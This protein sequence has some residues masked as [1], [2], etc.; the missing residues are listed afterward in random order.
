[1]AR[2][3]HLACQE[4]GSPPSPS[5]VTPL[6]NSRGAF[7]LEFV[8]VNATVSVRI[9]EDVNLTVFV[10][11]SLRTLKLLYRNFEKQSCFFFF[12]RK[13][14]LAKGWSTKTWDASRLR[15]HDCKILSQ[16]NMLR[17]LFLEQQ[18]RKLS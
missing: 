16:W 9:T 8:C 17:Q 13:A 15:S 7:T 4:G 3:L 6:A 18:K 12:V 10:Q 5:S 14:C 1:V 2:L 11:I